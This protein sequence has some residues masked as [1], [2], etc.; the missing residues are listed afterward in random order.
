LNRER[1]N[2]QNQVNG[3]IVLT[4]TRQHNHPLF[5][6]SL[7]SKLN[8]SNNLS[9][10]QSS[11]AAAQ[12][13]AQINSTNNLVNQIL[14]LPGTGFMQTNASQP[15]TTTTAANGRDSRCLLSK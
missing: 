2:L 14:E 12:A 4:S 6:K 10:S 15:T 3:G 9:A 13:Q 7:T 8:N 1:E 5:G 11:Q